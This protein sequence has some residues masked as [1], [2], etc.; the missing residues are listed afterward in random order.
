MNDE[1]IASLHILL[2]LCQYSSYGQYL[3][4]LYS[5]CSL[6]EKRLRHFCNVNTLIFISNITETVLERN[7]SSLNSGGI[8]HSTKNQCII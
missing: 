4:I 5:Q 8:L 2:Y 1:Q 3:G 6:M 7:G